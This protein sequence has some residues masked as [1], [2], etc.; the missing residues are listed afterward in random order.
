M[1]RRQLLWAAPLAAV[2]LV[3]PGGWGPRWAAMGAAGQATPG[4]GG[5]PIAELVIDLA[6]EP[7]TL[8]PAVSYDADAW[9]VVHSIHDSLLQYAA[10]GGLEPLLAERFEL[11]DPLTYEVA[12]RP[13]LVF[14]DGTPV[15]AAAIAGSVARLVD[16][17]TASQV[18]DLFRVIEAVETIDP[19]TARLRLAEPAPW[20]P[21]Q[22]A[23]WLALVPPG[24]AD[25]ANA[26]IGSGPFRFVAWQRGSE[27]VLEAN[28]DYPATS[29]KGRPLAG[30]VR[31]RFVPEGSTRVADLL[32][33]TSQI[34]REVP[35]DQVAAVEGEA[36][37]EVRVQPISGSAWVRIPTDVAPFD[38]VRVRRALN[39]AVD[40][41][42]I[43]G[44]LL[45][46]EG[47]RLATFFVE[48]GLG[49]DPALAPYAYD[50][51]RARAL[52]AE[53][54][55]GE[56][57]ATRLAYAGGDRAAVVE[58]IAG[59]LAEV[60]IRAEL[61]RVETATFNGTWTDPASAPLRFVTWRPLFDPYT[62][63][64]LLISD[65]GFLSRHANPAAQPLIE[66]A[67]AESDPGRRAETYRELAR[68]LHDEP[69]AIYLYNLTSRYGTSAAAAAVGAWTARADDYIIPT[70][71]G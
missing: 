9:S 66:A 19:L 38:D 67:A 16:P 30:R 57:F 45:G 64:N 60:G 22:I 69:A 6:T 7:P 56:G 17:A 44:A 31:F 39:H 10:D 40:V 49:F 23:A 54:G 61:E 33:G 65:A 21:A 36:E 71:R 15:E 68:V 50:P 63:L 42:A 25:P 27:I 13:G 11:L 32:A 58:A 70:T 52:L 43:V 1:N 4:G 14:H 5:E 37:A 2:P 46:G 29:P 55:H 28:A 26:P 62:L 12:L 47:E 20:L 8:D 35:V 34:V 53:A 59:Q 41:E 18:G 48:G 3:R 24:A 51:E